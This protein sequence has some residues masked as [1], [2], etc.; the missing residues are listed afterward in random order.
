MKKKFSIPSIVFIEIYEKWLC[1]NEFCRRVY[2]DVF[3]PL[4]KSHNIEIR[5]TDK[6]VLHSLIIINPFLQNHD[7][8]D[9]LILASA[10]TLEASLITS[11]EIIIECVQNNNIKLEVFY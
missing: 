9:K 8:H 4:R 1:S 2:Y 5:E 10:L 6:E 3:E 7:L 11:D